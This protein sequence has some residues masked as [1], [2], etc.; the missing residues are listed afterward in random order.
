MV[1]LQAVDRIGNVTTTNFDYTLDYSSDTTP[2]NL[3]IV[4]PTNE[5]YVSGTNFTLQ[6]QVDDDTATVTAQIIDADGDTNTMAGT[7]GR[8]GTVWVQNLPLAAGANSLTLTATDAA[9]NASRTNLTVNQSG[10]Q[11]TVTPLPADQ[12]GLFSVT[13][14]GTVSDPT[15]RVY[16]NGVG[17]TVNGDGTWEAD[18]V[19]V[20]AGNTALLDVLVYPASAPPDDGGAAA[21]HPWCGRRR[22]FPMKTVCRRIPTRSGKR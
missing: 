4:W 2:P 1:T 19:P 12:L 6:A 7:G 16:V 15:A 5:A 3:A 11:V 13:V 20:S 8:D 9:G 17:A 22:V 14:T 10:V 18:G 21:A